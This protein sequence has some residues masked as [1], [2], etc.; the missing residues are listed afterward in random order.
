MHI[1]FRSNIQ[2]FFS[3]CPKEINAN[4]NRSDYRFSFLYL[5]FCTLHTTQIVHAS[6]NAHIAAAFATMLPSI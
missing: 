2:V 5:N 6:S 1:Y 4:Q 3:L